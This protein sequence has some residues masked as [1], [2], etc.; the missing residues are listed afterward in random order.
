MARILRLLMS[1]VAIV[2]CVPAL[3]DTLKVGGTGVA[4]GGM[5][6]LG[7]AFQELHLGKVV[8]VL[9]SLGSSGGVK[10]VLAGAIDIGV[11]SRPLTES[12]KEAGAQEREYAYT[13]FAI[14]TSMGTEAEGVTTR[15]LEAI[16]SGEMVNWPN[17][18]PIRVIM[19]PAEET[20]TKMLRSLS[21]GMAKAV[22]GALER[23]GLVTA[24]TDQENAETLESLRGTIGIV[25]LG[26]IAAE[27]RHLKVLTLDGQMPSLDTIPDPESAF[28]KSLY[29]VSYSGTSPLARSFMAFVF[30]EQGRA[31]LLSLDYLPI[32]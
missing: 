11:S 24:I 12:E 8:K 27:K 10:A 7:D 16:Y 28:G 18:E 5:I 6:R 13:P 4:L 32:D 30:S 1:V 31:I 20:D 23:S 2:F 9:P 14:V 21:A 29:L 17:G 15:E 22:D 19:R 25:T 3:A 26:Q